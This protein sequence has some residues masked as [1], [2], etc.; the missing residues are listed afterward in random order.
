MKALVGVVAFLLMAASAEAADLVPWRIIPA[1]SMLSFTAR[2][3]TGG[4]I[5]GRFGSFSGTILF[6]P[7]RLAESKINIDVDVASVSAGLP[8]AQSNLPKPAW[9]SI[10]AFPKAHYESMA[11]AK[12]PDGQYEAQG[13]LS[14]KGVSAPVTLTFSLPTFGPKRAVAKG[15]ARLSR[16][17]FKVGQGDKENGPMVADPV[18]LAFTI[19]AE[20]P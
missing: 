13:T 4:T 7:A 5:T 16:G 1:E 11:L 12:R 15:A 9:L 19:T 17:V 18:D 10:Q 2:D 3:A 6:D 20:Q 14:L 8:D